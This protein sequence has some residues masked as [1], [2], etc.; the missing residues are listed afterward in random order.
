MYLCSS[1]NGTL[2][3]L[4]NDAHNIGRDG[5][6]M[7][8]FTKLANMNINL[9][10]ED[11]INLQNKTFSFHLLKIQ[12]FVPILFQ[13]NVKFPIITNPKVFLML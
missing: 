10:T 6:S 12:V 1:I 3:Q 13:L 11:S 7:T 4:S 5:V 2:P 9:Y 8:A